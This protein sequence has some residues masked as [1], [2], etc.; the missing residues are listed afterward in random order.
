VTRH[1]LTFKPGFY[2]M[3]KSLTTVEGVGLMLDPKLELIRLAKPF[4]R[5]I[6]FG[7]LRPGRILEEL[8]LTGSAYVHLLRDLPEEL[9]TLL[10]QLRTG[11]MRF[12]FEHRGLKSLGDALDRISNR[13]AFAIVLAALIVGS[14]LIVLSGIPPYWQGIPVIGLVGFL[15]A[16]IMGFWLLLSIIRHGR[17]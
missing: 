6:Q 5:K 1:K 4:M 14:S 9:R 16:G 13:I 11:R 15:V 2:Q 17:M 8:S 3:L 12:E 7:R 10:S